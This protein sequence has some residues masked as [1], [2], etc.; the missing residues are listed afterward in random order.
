MCANRFLKSFCLEELPLFKHVA[1]ES[2]EGVLERCTLIQ[3]SKNDILMRKSEANNYLYV[4]LTG[5]LN[6]RLDSADG[7]PIIVLGR[8]E[9][10][11]EMSI[12]DHKGVSAYVHASDDCQLLAIDE[13]TLWA[14]VSVS[15]A[16]ACNLLGIL[17]SRLRNTNI[18]LSE[19][20]KLE[21]DF[22][23]FGSADSLTGLHNRHW[24]DSTLPRLIRRYSRACKPISM[25]MTDIDHFKDFNTRYGHTTGDHVIHSVARVLSEHLR[26]SELAARYGGDEFVILM[27]GVALEN[28]RAAAERLQRIVADT[29]LSLPDKSPIR[30]PTISIGIAEYRIGDSAAQFLAAA[31][32]AMFRAK[33]LGRDTLSE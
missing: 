15:H 30:T 9:T 12:I 2:I 26:P 4:I 3:L 18:V 31:D 6:V 24:L 8:G 28:A 11:G 7:D 13:E 17:T 1:A 5:E 21:Y 19:R 23:Q 20:M 29:T 27:P 32:A 10:V 33:D 25:I 22:H 16:A 14:L